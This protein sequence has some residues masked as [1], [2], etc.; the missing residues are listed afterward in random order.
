MG[1]V[2]LEMPRRCSDG[3]AERLIDTLTPAG[4]FMVA[5]VEMYADES[6]SGGVLTVAAY[7]YTKDEALA[8]EAEWNPLLVEYGLPYFHMSECA[9]GNGI[10]AKFNKHE[11][12]KIQT[13]FFDALKRHVF[14]GLA[15]SY[16]LVH[17]HLL[18]SA[19]EIGAKQLTP[20]TFCCYYLLH[21]ARAQVAKNHPDAKIAYFFEAGAT[22]QSQANHLLASLYKNDYT[23]GF[24]KFASFS[25]VPKEH[26]AGIQTGDI[27]AWQWGKSIK[28]RD[29]GKN[30]VRADLRSLMDRKH[31]ATRFDAET[32]HDFLRVIDPTRVVISSPPDEA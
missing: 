32:I 15:V 22:H 29:E 13:R 20:Y 18:P 8:L 5:L 1:S 31:Y 14:C 17:S 28:D 11:R 9:H 10:F 25:F 6:E 2:A 21:N 30:K 23:N 3:I 12:I 4:G 7:V 19:I 26:S 16:E 27:F 24:F